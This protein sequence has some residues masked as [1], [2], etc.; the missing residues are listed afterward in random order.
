M[1]SRARVAAARVATAARAHQDRTGIC[2]ASS[3]SMMRASPCNLGLD[4]RKTLDHRHVGETVGD[5]LGKAAVMVLDGALQP[6]GAPQHA[7]W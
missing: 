4:A 6:L 3:A 2:A 1:V 7:R 5:A